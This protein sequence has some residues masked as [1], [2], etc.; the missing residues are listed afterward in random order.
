MESSCSAMDRLRD[1]RFTAPMQRILGTT[2]LVS[3]VGTGVLG[4]VYLAFTFVMGGLSTL[5]APEGIAAMQGI[6]KAIVSP[7]FLFVFVGMGVT[8]AGLVVSAAF[9]W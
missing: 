5:R 6:D 9:R 3:A 4:G 8:C 1:R 7:P 2:L